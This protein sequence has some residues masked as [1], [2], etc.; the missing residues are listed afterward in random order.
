MRADAQ[1]IILE[2][3]EPPFDLGLQASVTKFSGVPGARWASGI[4]LSQICWCSG[5]DL[6]AHA[7]EVRSG[8]CVGSDNRTSIASLRWFC[9]MEASLNFATCC[10]SIA[11]M[12]SYKNERYSG[13]TWSK[14]ST[15]GV[16]PNLRRAP[17]SSTARRPSQ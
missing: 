2:N 15:V 14:S 3:D 16:T 7:L 17:T 12:K 10:L 1:F 6:G 13:G 9:A 11:V 5:D 8:V 4:I